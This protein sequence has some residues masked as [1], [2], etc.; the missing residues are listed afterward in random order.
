MHSKDLLQ[1]TKDIDTQ[2]LLSRKP[3]NFLN[4][5]GN[6][7]TKFHRELLNAY[8]RFAE[9]LVGLAVDFGMPFADHASQM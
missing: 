4:L 5:S 1:V 9:D 3:L 7:L 2:N 8:S 6:F